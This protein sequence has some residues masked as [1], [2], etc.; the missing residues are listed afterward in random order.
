[1]RQCC[2]P[3]NFLYPVSIRKNYRGYKLNLKIRFYPV[4][5]NIL[6]FFLFFR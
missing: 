4:H 3:P 6:L 5:V 1:M 2:N